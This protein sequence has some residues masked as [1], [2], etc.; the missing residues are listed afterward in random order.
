MFEAMVSELT[1]AFQEQDLGIM[2][3]RSKTISD[4]CSYQSEEQIKC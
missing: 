3:E 2:T 4:Q 1:F